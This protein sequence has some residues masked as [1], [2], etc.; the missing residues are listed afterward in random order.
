MY[1]YR[2][3]RSSE[4]LC[5][6]IIRASHVAFT[7]STISGAEQSI[8][9]YAF[10]LPRPLT[11][12]IV[13]ELLDMGCDINQAAMN[14]PDV[15]DGWS[16]LFLQ[17]LRAEHPR[18]SSEFEIVRLLI[19][20]RANWFAKDA[21]GLTIFDHVNAALEKS[22]M[23]YQRDLWYCA[24]QREGI[25]IDATIETHPRIAKYNKYYTLGHYLALRY[26]D[27]WT[28]ENLSRQLQGL[29]EAC[30]WS[31]EEI[32][33]VSRIREEKARLA[34]EKREYDKKRRQERL[35]KASHYEW[36]RW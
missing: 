31:D 14:L 5:E 19:K 21:C 26:F 27:H 32:S 36:K 7:G 9:L 13:K 10:R 22:S 16:C 23:S 1:C 2:S 4:H 25:A 20:Q 24:L 18:F 28:G 8:L 6:R 34:E 29:L 3:D 15:P 12:R 33:E 11:L 35:E 30:L 17:V